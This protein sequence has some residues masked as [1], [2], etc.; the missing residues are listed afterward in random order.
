[1]MK[2]RGLV[3]FASAFVAALMMVFHA[4]VNATEADAAALQEL[5]EQRDSAK[6]RERRLIYNNDGNDN[7]RGEVTPERFLAR[8]FNALAGTPV[9]SIFYCTGV[10]NK[11]THASQVSEMLVYSDNIAA[12]GMNPYWPHELIL[13][14][15]DTLDL[16]ID[17]AREHDK[18]IFWSM[19]MNDNHDGYRGTWIDALMSSWK[20]MHPDYVMGEAG[21]L[22]E[23]RGVNT[24]AS[25]NWSI[26]EVREKAFRILEDVASRRDVDGI[27]LDFLRFPPYFPEVLDEEHA[28]PDHIELMTEFMRR[29]RAMTER[30]GL[31]RGRPILLAVRVFDSTGASKA[32][33]LD[34]ETWAEESLFDLLIAGGMAQFEPWENVVELGHK[35]DLPVYPVVGDHRV[36]AFWNNEER[37]RG[38]ALAAWRAGADGLYLFNDFSRPNRDVVTYEDLADPDRLSAQPWEYRFFKGRTW[39]LLGVPDVQRYFL[40]VTVEPKRRVFMDVDQVEVTLT[41]PREGWAIYYTTDGEP[42]TQD[43]QRYDHPILLTGTA[44][45]RAKAFGPDGGESAEVIDD[46]ELRDLEDFPVE[47]LSLWVFGL[48]IGDG[49]STIVE[50]ESLPQT[51]FT[52]FEM[53]IQDMDTQDEGR[54]YINGHGPLLPPVDILHFG[55]S[56][57]ANMDIP[58]EWL[59]IGENV[60]TFIFNDNLEGITAGFM[61]HSIE[62]LDEE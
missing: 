55:E 44:T 58:T 18:E 33:G 49:R 17:F 11:Y 16:A 20:Q 50:V 37:L 56:R 32:S 21:Q 27:E 4:E 2:T 35:Y 34:W 53:T 40:D 59:K 25:L 10:F 23:S 42:V 24:W 13:Q 7:P 1:M 62:Q 22:W 51:E 31:R 39:R 43:A 15:R 5:R 26:P 48:P 41:P 57:T 14:G 8:R 38:E 29:V 46:F 28:Y 60:F 3:L 52:T 12:E 6:W 61:V 19:R 36:T 30:E 54:I 9:D 45:V 47:P